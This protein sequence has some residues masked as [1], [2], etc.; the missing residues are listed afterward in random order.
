[1]FCSLILF[2]ARTTRNNGITLPTTTTLLLLIIKKNDSWQVNLLQSVSFL[3]QF[4]TTFWRSNYHTHSL[5]TCKSACLGCCSCEFYMT[6]L[7]W[8]WKEYIS[9]CFSEKFDRNSV[10]YFYSSGIS[11]FSFK[12][13][14]WTL[15]MRIWDDNDHKITLHTKRTLQLRVLRQVSRF[16]ENEKILLFSLLNSAEHDWLVV[17]WAGLSTQT[18]RQVIQHIKTSYV[19]KSQK[20]KNGK[21]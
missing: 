15:T 12:I 4:F 13:K 3:W 20:G 18:Q 10:K 1:M 6:Q 14:K 11:T 17:Y 21:I 2:T 5:H 16:T 7:K 19:R 9:I 8:Q